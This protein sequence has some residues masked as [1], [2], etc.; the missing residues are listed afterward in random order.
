MLFSCCC[1]CRCRCCRFFILPFSCFA[2]YPCGIFC[3]FF[4]LRF[5]SLWSTFGALWKRQSGMWKM[6]IKNCCIVRYLENVFSPLS[7]SDLVLCFWR[8][9]AN[10][11]IIYGVNF[12]FQLTE[13]QLLTIYKYFRIKYVIMWNYL[14]IC[15][16]CKILEHL[17]IHRYK[18]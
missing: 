2:I 14:C 5:F 8:C 16:I 1:R 6:Q 7:T 4:F 3:G 9:N 17:F 11:S 15:W 13:T 18:T 10:S 12:L